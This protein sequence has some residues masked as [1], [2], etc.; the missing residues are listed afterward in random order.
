MEQGPK[1]VSAL[2]A[3]DW[4]A[5]PRTKKS[6]CCLPVTPILVPLLLQEAGMRIFAHT[7]CSQTE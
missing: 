4:L 7:R 1:P 3:A 6:P 5:S 2:L